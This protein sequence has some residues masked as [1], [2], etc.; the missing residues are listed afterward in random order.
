MTALTL[1]PAQ[2][3]AVLQAQVLERRRAGVAHEHDV[4]LV[5]S[6]LVLSGAEIDP[7]F[8]AIANAVIAKAI[9][10]DKGKLPRKR[11]GAKKGA[12]VKYAPL[13]I[14]EQY[15]DLLDNGNSER[16]CLEEL[17]E[18][19]KKQ[20]NL[21]EKQIGRIVK[22]NSW[23][24]GDSKAHRDQRRRDPEYRGMDEIEPDDGNI[25]LAGLDKDAALGKLNSIISGG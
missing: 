5:L 10:T 13:A 7:A 9:V 25:A 12:A 18:R 4:L 6:A 20:H 2:N 11:P 23:L 16:D 3:A 1:T 19:Y 8:Q 22:D 24:F 15:F 14:T 21:S 17:A